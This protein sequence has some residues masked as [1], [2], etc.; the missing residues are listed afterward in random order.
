MLPIIQLARSVHEQSCYR[1]E[2][3]AT[4]QFLPVKDAIAKECFNDITFDDAFYQTT[5]ILECLVAAGFQYL[6]SILWGGMIPYSLHLDQPFIYARKDF[7]GLWELPGHG[8]HE[9]L[10]KTT[11]VRSF[12]R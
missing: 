4:G 1:V 9:T 12:W 11:I 10:L 7:P 2:H 5:D 3:F 6:S 8:S